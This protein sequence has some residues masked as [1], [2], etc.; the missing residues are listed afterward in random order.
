MEKTDSEAKK[1]FLRNS[2]IKNRNPYTHTG[3]INTPSVAILDQK[4]TPGVACKRINTPEPVHIIQVIRILWKYLTAFVFP[5]LK[6]ENSKNIKQQK[7][8][9]VILI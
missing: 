9:K 3:T 4:R 6:K 7:A 5:A 8:P 2:S 1:T